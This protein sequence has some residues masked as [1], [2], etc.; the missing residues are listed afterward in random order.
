APIGLRI[1]FIGGFFPWHGLE[2]L[3]DVAGRVC[4]QRGDVHFILAGSGRTE[5]EIRRQV[6][7]M[8]LE[9]NVHF[10]GLIPMEKA[11]AFISLLDLGWCVIKPVRR[12]L[13]SPLKL[14]EYLSCGVPVVA[15]DSGFG[16]WVEEIK[17]GVT[18]A[19]G[20]SEKATQKIL[21]LMER[22]EQI[23]EMGHR[24]RQAVLAGHTWDHR[25]KELERIFQYG[26]P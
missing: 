16:D 17:G 13:G 11:C 9:K 14:Y 21:A 15:N 25:A 3:V 20:D 22:P 19:Y 10:L 4:G 18:V 24:G 7:R 26:R 12:D 8:D 1:G 6:R 5:P 2:F 23:Q